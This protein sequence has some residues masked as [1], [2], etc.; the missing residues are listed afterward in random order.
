[1]R[2]KRSII[3]GALIAPMLALTG[4]LAYAAT[5]GTGQ[6][7]PASHPAATATATPG[8]HSQHPAS[9]VGH[10]GHQRN[11]SHRWCDN[12]RSGTRHHGTRHHAYQGQSYQGYGNQGPRYR[13]HGSY[14]GN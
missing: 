2:N 6:G 5:S 11:G 9:Q 12:Q 1:M 10:H 8:S 3:I 4:G 13:H 14:Q 7:H